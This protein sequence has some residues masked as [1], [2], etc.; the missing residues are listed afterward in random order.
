[1]ARENKLSNF[2]RNH[3]MTAWDL[4]GESRQEIV[5]TVGFASS[6]GMYNALRAMGWIDGGPVSGSRQSSEKSDVPKTPRAP[7][8][9]KVTGFLPARV[10]GFCLAIDKEPAGE[11]FV[12]DDFFGLIESENKGWSKLIDKL[13]QDE[14][15]GLEAWL[16][17]SATIQRQIDADISAKMD[18]F[19]AELKAQADQEA[20]DYW[21]FKTNSEK[22]GF[23]PVTDDF[24]QIHIMQLWSG[25]MG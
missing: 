23:R 4:G 16:G 24:G 9:K 21:Q 19:Y 13:G 17:R 7:K 20:A 25:F 5:K 6:N 11:S 2:D 18:E 12:P 10:E 3:V 1:M 22:F 15:D 14:I 8:A